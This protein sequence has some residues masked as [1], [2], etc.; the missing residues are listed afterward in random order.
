[1]GVK[2]QSDFAGEQLIYNW[3]KQT[4][5]TDKNPYNPDDMDKYFE[6]KGTKYYYNR[7]E[8][9]KV[10]KVAGLI[11]KSK[12]DDKIRERADSS[13]PINIANPSEKDIM[14]VK[15]LI[16]SGRQIARNEIMKDRGLIQR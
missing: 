3:N 11:A 5:G 15:E 13:D 14:L 6:F 2:K 9:Y 7:E 16:T 12:L 1:M 10:Q 4:E 8:W